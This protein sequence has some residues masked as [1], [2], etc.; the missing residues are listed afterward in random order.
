MQRRIQNIPCYASHGTPL[1]SSSKTYIS[2]VFT[3]KWFVFSLK[4]QDFPLSKAMLLDVLEVVAPVK[5][6]SKLREF[7]EMKLPP[8]F[9]VKVDIPIL[10]TITT[11]VNFQDF[12]FRNNMPDTLFQIPKDY[13]ENPGR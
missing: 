1:I 10:P 12:E 7:V 5:H 6:F 11:R 13:V 8:G 2:Q 3:D 9:P 4:C